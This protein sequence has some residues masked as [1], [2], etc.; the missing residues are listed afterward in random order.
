MSMT[1]FLMYQLELCGNHIDNIITIGSWSRNA[2][3]IIANC[4]A[5]AKKTLY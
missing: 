2:F 5:E 3:S 4:W 1:L